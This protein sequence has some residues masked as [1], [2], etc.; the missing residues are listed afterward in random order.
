MAA[1]K[2]QVQIRGM[3]LEDDIT[4]RLQSVLDAHAIDHGIN[5]TAGN[6]S[7]ARPNQTVPL[8]AKKPL[9]SAAKIGSW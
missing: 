8:T 4:H 3:S 9:T 2:L 7:P 6:S 5:H 1:V